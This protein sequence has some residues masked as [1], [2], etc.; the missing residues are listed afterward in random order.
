MKEDLKLLKYEFVVC[1]MFYMLDGEFLNIVSCYLWYEVIV[2]LYLFMGDYEKF[3][4]FYLRR[5]K[6]C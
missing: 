5:C 3:L 4:F 2:C 6:V 1:V